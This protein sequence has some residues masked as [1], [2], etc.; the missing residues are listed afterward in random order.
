[1]IVRIN[2][3]ILSQII[4]KKSKFNIHVLQFEGAF[5]KEPQTTLLSP[6]WKFVLKNCFFYFF[7]LLSADLSFTFDI[8]FDLFL[9]DPFL[10]LLLRFKLLI[11]LGYD[12]QFVE[13]SLFLS[14]RSL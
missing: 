3:A 12:L 5:L 2:K 13:E 10:L 7:L 14:E 8:L 9:H 1:M 6:V 4:K 11:L